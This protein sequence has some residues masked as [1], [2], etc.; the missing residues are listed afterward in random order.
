MLRHFLSQR[1]YTNTRGFTLLELL[2]VIAIMSIA[3]G[4]VAPSLQF[5]I[6]KSR[7]IA[8][9][10]ELNNIIRYA[11]LS[12]I[13]EH[14]TVTIC[15]TTN[16]QTC[17]NNWNQSLIIFMD[18]NHNAILDHDE[19]LLRAINS[20]ATY[21]SVTGPNAYIRFYASGANSTPAS[22]VICSLQ[23]YPELN[24]GLFISL[25]GRTRLSRDTNLDGLHERSN[26][27]TLSC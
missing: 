11:R 20:E 8:Q 25:Q 2:V 24:R 6:A 26:G 10:N 22:L 13:D 9:R 27:D 7:V 17:A 23:D 21:N 19:T 5:T 14:A 18:E 4:I 3:L 16:M 1:H 12:A 15:P